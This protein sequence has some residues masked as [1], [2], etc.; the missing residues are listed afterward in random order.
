MTFAPQATMVHGDAMRLTQIVSN[1][2]SNA[3]RY[4][5]RGGTI[6]VSVS[7]IG[8]DARLEV[9]DNGEG[10]TPELL[11]DLF[12]PF[13]QAKRSSDRTNGG[14][15]IGLPLVKALVDAHGSRIAVA[16]EGSGKGS[17]FT[18]DLALSQPA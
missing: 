18:V 9:A 7:R 12:V 8:N 1:L 6:D 10:I 2:L 4:T 16:S 15:G 5:P 14:L 17:R 11:P 3:I 13:V